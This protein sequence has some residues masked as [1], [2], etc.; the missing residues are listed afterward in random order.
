M[1]QCRAILAE[2]E[3]NVGQWVP[4]PRLVAASGAYA[5]H[6]RISELRAAGHVIET[7]VQIGRPTHSFYR[8]MPATPAVDAPSQVPQDSSIRL[9]D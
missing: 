1:S 4:M 5:V 3:R 2:L 7:R 6:S 8:L 9:S